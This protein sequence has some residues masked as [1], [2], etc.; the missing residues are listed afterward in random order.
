MFECPYPGCSFPPLH[1]GHHS[2]EPI[3]QD[4]PNCGIAVTVMTDPEFPKGKIEHCLRAV[5]HSN[6]HTSDKAEIEAEPDVVPTPA[7]ELPGLGAPTPPVIG[8]GEGV[9]TLAV[10]CSNCAYSGSADIPR[11]YPLA[12]VACPNCGCATLSTA[13]VAL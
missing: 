6:L 4:R 7:P 1:R 9:Y 8:V 5:G 13:R 2:N 11:G 12:S 3:I 10:A